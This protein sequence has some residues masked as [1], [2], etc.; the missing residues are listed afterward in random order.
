MAG[1]GGESYL[2]SETNRRDFGAL[3]QPL[4]A[5]PVNCLKLTRGSLAPH[6]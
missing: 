6:L 4:Q 5:V 2:D 1:P 3:P